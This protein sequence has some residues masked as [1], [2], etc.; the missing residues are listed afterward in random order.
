MFPLQL[1]VL[2]LVTCLAMKLSNGT[3]LLDTY[4]IDLNHNISLSVK[5]NTDTNIAKMMIT[6]SAIP[7]VFKIEFNNSYSLNFSKPQTKIIIEE[8]KWNIKLIP[9]VSISKHTIIDNIEILELKRERIGVYTFPNTTVSINISWIFKN[10]LYDIRG[11][12]IL[13][14][15]AHSTNY[16]IF[17]IKSIF[18]VSQSML[19]YMM[20][21]SIMQHC[22]MTFVL[23]ARKEFVD[24]LLNCA[25]IF[26]H[27]WFMYVWVYS[28]K[29]TIFLSV[30]L[31]YYFN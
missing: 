8:R 13:N 24:V 16:T 11:K 30:A 28:F 10:D 14:L 12:G 27:D 22:M 29:F 15:T 9:M 2:I 25:L 18:L 17:W 19:C 1:Y 5:I 6:G 31:F 23:F 3:I 26:W 7:N 20:Y 21:W 4:I